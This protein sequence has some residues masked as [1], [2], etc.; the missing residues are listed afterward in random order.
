MCSM[1][2]DIAQALQL[3]EKWQHDMA[4]GRESM[5]GA[6]CLAGLRLQVLTQL[7]L[8][9]YEILD[10]SDHLKRDAEVR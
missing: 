4:D 1:R 2:G 5:S 3:M 6:C 7:V 9:A 10:G 8:T